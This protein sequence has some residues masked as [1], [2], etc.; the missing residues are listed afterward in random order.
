MEQMSAND[1]HRTTSSPWFEP[2]PVGPIGPATEMEL[3]DST[4]LSIINSLFAVG[5]DLTATRTM[6]DGGAAK[7][8]DRAIQDLDRLIVDVRQRATPREWTDLAV[9]VENHLPPDPRYGLGG[10]GGPGLC[11]E[12]GSGLPQSPSG[13]DGGEQDCLHG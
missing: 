12:A 4:V 1:E 8:I 6:V 11:N 3:V 10:A 9:A 2:T 5:L 7:R 13:L